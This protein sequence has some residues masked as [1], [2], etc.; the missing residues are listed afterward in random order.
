MVCGGLAV[1]GVAA[2]LVTLSRGGWL[3][4]AGA[5]S[6]LAVVG[7]RMRLLRVPHV[8]FAG[9]L[10]G[11][12]AVGVAVAYPTFYYRIFYSDQRAAEAR[13][14]LFSQATMVI[15]EA[16]LLGVGLGGYNHAARQEL[17]PSFGGL[18]EGFR[19]ALLKE[20]V[21]HKYAAVWAEQGVV[22]LVL[23]LGIF[24]AFI[25]RFLRVRRWCDPACAAIG[26]GLVA[27][28]VGQLIFY[29]FEHFY[30]ESRNNVLWIAFGVLAGLSSLNERTVAGSPLPPWS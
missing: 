24:V 14:A 16:P 20:V 3:S 13:L 1:G 19:G 21:H 17:H 7:C 2:L 28:L 4:L 25:R 9:I 26:L 29:N 10:V 18:S 6:F 15:R 5:L 22:G 23:W 11:L 27:G 30:T 8:I 12:L